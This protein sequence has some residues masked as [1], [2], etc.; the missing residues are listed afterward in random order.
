MSTLQMIQGNTAEISDLEFNVMSKQMII[1][2]QRNHR[3]S[4]SIVKDVELDSISM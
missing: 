4:I 3:S 1:S 2:L